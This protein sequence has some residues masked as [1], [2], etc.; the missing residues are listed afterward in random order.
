MNAKPYDSKSLICFNKEGGESK[1]V[2]P[3]N[4]SFFLSASSS[5]HCNQSHLLL[6]KIFLDIFDTRY[7]TMVL[8]PDSKYCGLTGKNG[9]VLKQLN[10]FCQRNVRGGGDEQ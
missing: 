2:A 7:A 1:V 3:G 5:V 6:D 4:R 9:M 8:Y 10:L